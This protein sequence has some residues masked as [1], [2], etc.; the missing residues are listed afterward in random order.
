MYSEFISEKGNRMLNITLVIVEDDHELKERLTRIL[1]RKISVVKSFE[2]ASSALAALAT[3]KPDI[4]ITDIKMPEMNGLEMISIIR[5][6]YPNIPVIITSAFSETDYFLKAIELKIEHFLIKPI[7][8]EKL[9]EMIVEIADRIKTKKLL[10]E[11]QDLLK[12]Y[13]QIVDVSNNLTVTDSNGIIKY[14]N[15]KFVQLSGYAREELIGKSHNILH[16]PDMPEQFF[17]TMWEKIESKQV[18]QGIIKDRKKDGSIFYVETT[19]APILNTERVIVEYISLEVDISDLIMQRQQ[20]KEQL[21]TD[22]LTGLLNRLSLHRLITNEEHFTLMLINIDRFKEIN[23]LFGLHFGDAA[24]V[25]VANM[26]REACSCDDATV[27]RIGSDE[28]IVHRPED[29][30]SE[31]KDLADILKKNIKNKPFE[32]QGINFEIEF[33]CGIVLSMPDMTNHIECADAAMRIARENHQSLE[34]YN[35]QLGKQKEYEENFQWI[36]KIKE[37][38][39]ENRITI[40]YQPIINAKENIISKYECLVRL[41]EPNGEVISPFFFLHV[42]KRSSLYRQITRTVITQACETFL[43]RKETFSVNFSIEDLMDQDTLEFLVDKVT[44]HNLQNRIIIEV[45]ES[46]GIDNFDLIQD[47]FRYLKKHG[48]RIAIDDF[49]S[50]Y[51]NF[52]YI[53]NLDIDQLKIDGSLIKEI[54]NNNSS[55]V[56]V[57]SVVM[58]CHELGIKCVGEF[59]SDKSIY[60]AAM[61]LD[62]DFLQGYYLSKPLKKPLDFNTLLNL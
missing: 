10:I 44:T 30:I 7:D 23:F 34:V 31:L 61:A 12:Q 48:I 9:L 54:A 21:A 6:T 55:R 11:N 43:N 51:S 14:V 62:I 4:I 49:G 24:L 40:Y 13:K 56:I 17:K 52:S 59:V 22:H 1:S 53:I 29:K 25:Y 3:I 57:Q 20:L 33:T 15:D 38:L 16:H 41:I 58:F 28:Y 19:I 39:Q 50:G 36:R 26:I 45:L 47:V 42:A 37:A 35:F 46:E 32:F 5:K 27:Y 8:V 18:W 60:D 2:N